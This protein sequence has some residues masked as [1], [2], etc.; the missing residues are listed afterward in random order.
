MKILSKI[1]AL[2]AVTALFAGCCRPCRAYQ[3]LRRPLTN[4]SWQ[5]IQLYGQTIHPE[6]GQF[7]L[8]LSDDGKVQGMG[9]CNRFRGTFTTTPDRAIRIRDIVST[10]RMCPQADVEMQYFRLMQ[11][12]THYDMDGPMMMLLR[13]GEL[14]ALFQSLPADTAS[15]HP[16]SRD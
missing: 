15:R 5:L 2:L 4:T 9:A 12:A 11:G 7:T 16:S 3:K 10:R 6:E 1:T 13:E 8:W 14:V